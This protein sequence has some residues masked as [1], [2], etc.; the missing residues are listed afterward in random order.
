MFLPVLTASLDYNISVK[1][2]R[3][4][5]FSDQFGIRIAHPYQV[6]MYR[7]SYF[8]KNFLQTLSAHA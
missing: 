8:F 2:Y 6:Y 4:E 7:Y 1:Y 3:N 5:T